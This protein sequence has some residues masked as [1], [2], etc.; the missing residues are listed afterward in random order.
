MPA[1]T[2]PDTEFLELRRRVAQGFINRA[3]NLEMKGRTRERAAIDFM[4]GAA[5]VD[6]R[7]VGA[8]FLV[9]TRG[10]SEILE[11]AK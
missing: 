11:L 10:Y 4:C 5:T 2:E 7:L 9:A 8:A 6:S 3:A 1:Q